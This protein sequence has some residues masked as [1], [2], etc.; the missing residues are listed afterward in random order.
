MDDVGNVGSH[1]PDVRSG[2]Q[3]TDELMPPWLV[4]GIPV[5]YSSDA[6]EQA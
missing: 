5:G 4:R 3:L 2:G 6:A 1:R